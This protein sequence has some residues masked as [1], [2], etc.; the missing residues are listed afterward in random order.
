MPKVSN[1]PYHVLFVREGGQWAYEFGDYDRACVKSEQQ[2][3]LDHFDD[4][5]KRRR[6]KDTVTLELKTADQWR[7][8]AVYEAL[9][10]LGASAKG[11]AIGI[12]VL[13]FKL[14]G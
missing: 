11:Q 14:G 2:D 8:D 12:A 1:R 3:W 9:N 13:T 7:I 10:A 6:S 4:D 5:G